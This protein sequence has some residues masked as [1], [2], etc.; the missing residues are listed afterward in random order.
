MG[1]EARRA[2]GITDG[3]LRLSIGLEAESDLIA[4]IEAA[5]AA[6]VG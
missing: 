4:D 6:A 3:L 5:L 1:D 2:A